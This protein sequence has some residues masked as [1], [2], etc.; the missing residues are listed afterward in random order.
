MPRWTVHAMQPDA[1]KFWRL[2]LAI[3]AALFFGPLALV[4][5]WREASPAIPEL[6]STATS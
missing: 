6:V 1:R 2:A 3:S 5:S 4:L